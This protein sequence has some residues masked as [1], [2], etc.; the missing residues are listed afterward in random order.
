[1][2]GL[3]NRNHVICDSA[4]LIERGRGVRFTVHWRDASHPAFAIR[5]CGRVYAYLNVCAHRRVELDWDNG[6]F[7]ALGGRELICATHGARY[8]PDSGACVGGP[9]GGAGLKPLE[10]RESGGKIVLES[11]DAVHLNLVESK[12]RS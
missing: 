9:C 7:F 3:D 1:M 4:A 10:V 11:A 8:A 12:Q 5:F 2:A 6:E